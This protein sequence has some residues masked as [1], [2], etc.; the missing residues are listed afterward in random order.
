ME[1]PNLPENV[2][3]Q[4]FLRIPAL[5][6]LKFRRVCGRWKDL[7]SAQSFRNTHLIWSDLSN[8]ILLLRWNSFEP[9]AKKLTM[10]DKWEQRRDVSS[11]KDDKLRFD[12]NHDEYPL[13]LWRFNCIFR[14]RIEP[15]HHYF[16]CPIYNPVTV[17]TVII[18]NSKN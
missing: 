18:D 4:I 10:F 9:W 6:L 8:P 17:E 2:V 14:D 5:Q 3:I 15:E 12:M 7:L 16:A 13:F 1:P 11:F